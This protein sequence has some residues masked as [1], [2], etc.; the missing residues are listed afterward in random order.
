MCVTVGGCLRVRGAFFKGI[1]VIRNILRTY[2]RVRTPNEVC[3]S[4]SSV[5]ADGDAAALAL[6]L[7]SC[8]P[9]ADHATLT[10]CRCGKSVGV[11]EYVRVP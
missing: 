6:E 1:E 5:R 10:S 2:V 3:G 11:V 9:G 8:F 4:R 7:T